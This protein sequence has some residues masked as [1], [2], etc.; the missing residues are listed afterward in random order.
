ML[1]GLLW[2]SHAYLQSWEFLEKSYGAVFLVPDLQRTF[3][4]PVAALTR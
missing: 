4:R 2:L 1:G 3:R